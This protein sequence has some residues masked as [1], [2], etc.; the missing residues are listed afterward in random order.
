MEFYTFDA[1]FPH[2]TLAM[3]FLEDKKNLDFI[4]RFLAMAG[5]MQ[6]SLCS[7]GLTKTFIK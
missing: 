5:L 2:P 4:L 3:P 1:D 6:A 7:F